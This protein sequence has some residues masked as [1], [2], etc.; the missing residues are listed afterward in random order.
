MLHIHR[1]CIWLFKFRHLQQT[2]CTG[3]FQVEYQGR[4]GNT[5]ILK[6]KPSINTSHCNQHLLELKYFHLTQFLLNPHQAAQQPWKSE[7]WWLEIWSSR[8]SYG[9][10]VSNTVLIDCLQRQIAKKIFKSKIKACPVILSMMITMWWH[11]NTA[12]HLQ[13]IWLQT[14]VLI[15]SESRLTSFSSF[16]VE[17]SEVA[18]LFNSNLSRRP[19]LEQVVDW[20]LLLCRSKWHCFGQQQLLAYS[21]EI[22]ISHEKNWLVTALNLQSIKILLSLE[23]SPYHK[24]GSMFSSS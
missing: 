21:I 7:N 19:F 3:L 11:S 8:S 20:D 16:C 1:N 10:L 15:D 9:W 12:C 6:R 24:S 14:L 4:T 5:R 17:P 22:F 23:L 13:L 2:F 18:T